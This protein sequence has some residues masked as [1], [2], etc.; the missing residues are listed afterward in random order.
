MES[1]PSTGGCSMTRDA[2]YPDPTRNSGSGRTLGLLTLGAAL[3]LGLAACEEFEATTDV[4]VDPTFS[5]EIAEDTVR[6][7]AGADTVLD[8]SVTI[9][10]GGSHRGELQNPE[11][12]WAPSGYVDADGR[13][14]VP[15]PVQDLKL[16]AALDDERYT[17]SPDSVIV[18]AWALVSITSG[19][20]IRLAAIGETAQLDVVARDARGDTHSEWPLTVTWSSAD[21]GVV[22]VDGNG[23]ITARTNG[24][25][26]AVYAESDFHRDSVMVSVRQRLAWLGGPGSVDALN[27]PVTFFAYDGAD[28][29]YHPDD[30]RFHSTDPSVIEVDSLTGAGVTVGE[31]SVDIR[32]ATP[33]D[34]CWHTVTVAQTVTAVWVD[35]PADTLYAVDETAQLSAVPQ[36]RNGMAVDA[37]VGWTSRDE[38][39][40][41]V[42]DSG[43]VT[44]RG[45]GTVAVVASVGTVSDS[46]MISVLLPVDSVAVTPSSLTFTAFGDT[47]SA[48]ASAFDATGYERTDVVISWA[49]ADTLV[50][51][52]DE[53]GLMTATGDGT[54]QVTAT[55]EDVSGTLDLTVS[56]VVDTV[57]VSP[58]AD[59]IEALGGTVQLAADPQDANG[60]T[61]A[62]ATLAWASDDTLVATVD[63]SGVVTGV[64]PG[65]TRITATD[66]TV[67]GSAD[68]TVDQRVDSMAVSPDSVG[69]DALGA[70]AVL[71]V[72]AWDPGGAPIADPEPSWTSSDTLV[73]T[74]DTGVITS[75]GNG[76]ATVTVEADG[77]SATVKA[78]VEQVVVGV[79]VTPDS[80]TV[81]AL[82]DT[83]R[84]AGSAVDA[85]GFPVAGP[86]LAWESA[87]TLIAIVDSV[88]LVTA[89]AN[90]ETVVRATGGAGTDSAVVTVAQRVDSI[91]VSPEQMTFVAIGDSQEAIAELYDALGSIVVT[92]V[93]PVWSI[94]DTLVATLDTTTLVTVIAAGPGTTTLSATAGSVTGTAEVTVAQVADSVVVS[95]DTVRLNAIGYTSPVAID[96]Y[97]E[98][99]NLIVD[100]HVTWQSSDTLIATVDSVGEVTASANGTAA[101]VAVSD[102]VAD[103]A[104]AVVAQVPAGVVV[105]PPTLTVDMGGT[106]QLT[107]EVQDSNGVAI[108]G[109]TF[110][111]ASADTLIATV[112]GSGLVTGVDVGSTTVTATSGGLTGQADV[113]VAL[114]GLVDQPLA[115]SMN[116][117]NCDLNGAGQAYCWGNNGSGQ[118]GDGTNTASASPVAVSG[119]FTFAAVTTGSDHACGLTPQGE[120]YCWGGNWHGQLGDNTYDNRSSPTPVTG[121]YTFKQI[122]AA[123][124]TTC[125]LDLSGSAY[126][127]GYNGEGQIGYG[128]GDWDR[129]YPTAVAGGYQFERLDAG[130]E[131]VCGLTPAGDLYCWGQGGN[132]QIGDDTWSDRWEPS[133]VS[134]GYSW[135]QLSAGGYHT[136]AVTNTGAGYCWGNDDQWQLGHQS[137]GQGSPG[138]AVSGALTYQ[139]IEAGGDH[140]CGIL[141]DGQTVC[142]GQ[143]S[144]GRLGTGSD[145]GQFSSPQL[146]NTGVDFA[147]LALGWDHTCGMTA[148]GETWCWGERNYGAIGDGVAGSYRTP[149]QVSTGVAIAEDGLGEPRS[150]T[151]H[152][153]TDGLVYCAG[154]NWQ[155]Q[156]GD[157][158]NDHRYTLAPVASGEAFASVGGRNDSHA[159]GVT[160]SGEAYCW[161]HNWQGQLGSGPGDDSNTPILVAGGHLW[162]TVSAGGNHSCGVTDGG[163]VYCWGGNNNGQAGQAETWNNYDTPQLVDDTRTYVDVEVADEHSCALTDAGEVYCWGHDNNCVGVLGDGDWCQTY[164]SPNLVQGGLTFARLRV[165]HNHVCGITTT[166]EGYCWG[167][168]HR[169]QLGDGTQNNRNTPVR[170][171]LILY[172]AIDPGGNHTCGT[173]TDGTGVCWGG[174]DQG[175]L[176]TGGWSDASAPTL[177]NT[178]V[179]FVDLRGAGDTS[180]GVTAAN[181]LYCWGSRNGVFGDGWTHFVTEPVQVIGH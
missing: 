180:C 25:P 51:T 26:V 144:N 79:D 62:P 89:V 37:S 140:T 12:T 102:G 113:Q 31:G 154:Q 109:S 101:I 52:V 5:V 32:A 55:A 167:D 119:G 103:T 114:P 143:N 71:T 58:A 68:V 147:H 10:V 172:S 47:A 111:W 123:G 43:L 149:V 67:T 21:D 48:E 15:S 151:C 124:R 87:D 27:E 160:T 94:A 81:D 19:S 42:D 1:A 100:P 136:C 153:G 40:A 36:D 168:N 181:E 135:V 98:N 75:V 134:G 35:P 11:L 9:A 14:D 122:V 39:I 4:G 115:A 63:G 132:G 88:G 49:S 116:G 23:E 8:V 158:T 50:V 91:A 34:T 73:V 90:G 120:A 128:G 110:I 60:F 118:L 175:E 130:S 177:I 13:L 18:R 166:A 156:L 163:A 86:D 127:W 54:T 30:V 80:A 108:T 178:S 44:A 84:L 106:G 69:F 74:A 22:T 6:L 59:T 93:T 150:F 174:N 45:A 99:S 33:E 159:C 64:A 78:T 16:V 85:N 112:D 179:D 152:L 53:A 176:G 164:T 66:G 82:G 57:V 92:G 95:P 2:T 157:G 129:P 17:A 161:G 133:L 121:G 162:Q 104:W 131:H 138:I 56:Q 137:G 38:L 148:T 139:Y 107:A 29:P 3:G 46:A 70:A 20:P 141:T 155:G 126:C 165:A 146:V 7:P 96:V 61:V 117:W 24:G 170:A 41:T 105:D 97:D 83:T 125:A 145:D 173:K 77:V 171:G 76:T 72:G 28:E 169:G 142:W 65:T